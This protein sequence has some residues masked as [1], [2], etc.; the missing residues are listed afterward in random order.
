ME[1][2]GYPER[3][4]FDAIGPTQSMFFS[5]HHS[6]SILRR[7]M[8]A[9]IRPMPLRLA[10]PSALLLVVLFSVGLSVHPCRVLHAQSD[11]EMAA[12]E[13][14]M[15]GGPD[16]RGPDSRGPGSGGPGSGGPSGSVA[17]STIPLTETGPSPLVLWR[18]AKPDFSRLGE[19]LSRLKEPTEIAEAPIS[20]GPKLRNEAH[21]AFRYGN[22]PLARELFFGHLALGEESSASELQSILFSPH[23]RRPAWNLRWGLAIGVTGDTDASTFDPITAETGGGSFGGMDMG[24][25]MDM[26]DPDMMDRGQMGRGMGDRGMGDRGMMDPDMD[27]PD[28]MGMDEMFD[29]MGDGMGGGMGRNPRSAAAAVVIPEPAITDATIADRVS[30]LTGLVGQTLATGMTERITGGKFGTALVDV[31]EKDETQGYTVGGETVSQ[32]STRM[33]IPGVVYVGEGSTSEMVPAAKKE[34]IELLLYLVVSLKTSRTDEVQNICRVKVIDCKSGKT[35]VAS[36]GMD[37]REVKR[38]VA[39]KRGTAEAHITEE[40]ETFWKIIDTRLTLTALPN[41][42][43]EIARRRVTQI[44]GDPSYSKLRQLAE[45]RLLHQKSWLTD[46]ELEMAFEIM[47]GADG[48]K[49]LFGPKSESIPIIRQIANYELVKNEK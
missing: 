45:V 7:T 21:V 9:S 13:A 16:S 36:G 12:M 25:D 4:H 19:E 47:A 26:D 32:P 10:R 37:N 28:M 41:L 14:S 17:K 30:E 6:F 18:M 8:I 24:M 33:W 20:T 22:L 11:E 46:E 23:F 38:L 42:T 1:L 15:R 44:M 43:P 3:A 35:L 34:G 5:L 48:T 39:M 49:I 2:V 27:D 29:D 40:M 31:A